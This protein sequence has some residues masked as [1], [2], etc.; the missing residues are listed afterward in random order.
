MC[1]DGRNG[2]N[3]ASLQGSWDL[4]ARIENLWKKTI[5]LKTVVS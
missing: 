4:E 3:A 2:T 5:A 1:K